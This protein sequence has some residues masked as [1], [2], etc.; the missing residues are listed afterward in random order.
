[1]DLNGV[2]VPLSFILF[3]LA[4]AI[5]EAKGAPH[6]IAKVSIKTPAEVL[7]KKSNPKQRWIDVYG[8]LTEMEAWNKQRKVAQQS[9]T[10]S[11]HFLNSFQKVI[12]EFF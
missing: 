5:D 11:A 6:R 12:T 1:M 9:S 10:I 8:G 7:Y 3:L 4:R 2:F